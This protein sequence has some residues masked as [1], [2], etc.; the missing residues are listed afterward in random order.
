MSS[1]SFTMSL[2][3][4]GRVIL[5]VL[6]QTIPFPSTHGLVVSYKAEW[7]HI[8]SLQ[9]ELSISHGPMSYSSLPR[10]PR[11]I[12][13]VPYTGEELFVVLCSS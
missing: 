8:L 13:P 2:S 1:N 7:R 12:V 9:V 11:I 5:L 4:I 10:V 6:F 3:I